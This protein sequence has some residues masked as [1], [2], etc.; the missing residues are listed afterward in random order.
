MLAFGDDRRLGVWLLVVVA[1]RRQCYVAGELAGPCMSWC[2]E[3]CCLVNGRFSSQADCSGCTAGKW[4]CFPGAKCYETDDRVTA[5]SPAEASASA[6]PPA[7]ADVYANSV[8]FSAASWSRRRDG[9]E[10]WTAAAYRIAVAF[11]LAETPTMHASG[12]PS[13]PPVAVPSGTTEWRTAH[14]YSSQYVRRREPVACEPF[15]GNS[16]AWREYARCLDAWGDYRSSWQ[17]WRS[18]SLGRRGAE[19]VDHPE[20]RAQLWRLFLA[21]PFSVIIGSA[22][23]SLQLKAAFVTFCGCVV[24]GAACGL[25]RGLGYT[26][27]VAL[28]LGAH[29]YMDLLMGVIHMTLDSPALL[30]YPALGTYTT[31]FQYHHVRLRFTEPWAVHLFEYGVELIVVFHSAPLLLLTHLHPAAMPRLRRASWAWCAHLVWMSYMALVAHR[32]CHILDAD[33]VPTLVHLGMRSGILMSREQHRI[34]HK[35][36]EV[37]EGALHMTTFFASKRGYGWSFYNAWADSLLNF[38]SARVHYASPSVLGLTF[39]LVNNLPLLLLGI[40]RAVYILLGR[41]PRAGRLAAFVR[42][43][44]LVE[45]AWATLISQDARAKEEKDLKDI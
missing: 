13:P 33:E 11:G 29:Y 39:G 9:F 44:P 41:G 43:L 16:S 35:T 40:G 17:I 21:F 6:S 42:R 24:I 25:G 4:R 8:A 19:W 18:A 2:V 26:T 5:E 22:V 20:V 27:Q 3:D 37:A 34:H 12:P 7:T 30:H 28:L 32:C 14:S 38:I 36:F 15:V 1:G 10:P 31:S 45:W 23:M